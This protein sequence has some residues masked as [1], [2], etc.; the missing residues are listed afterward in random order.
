[1][2]DYRKPNAVFTWLSLKIL[3]VI[4]QH[5]STFTEN[6]E[7]LKD[8][9]PPYLVLGNHVNNWDPFIVNLFL[10]EPMAFVVGERLYQSKGPIG[11]FLKYIGAIPII[12]SEPDMTAV[13]KLIKAKQASRILCL[14][15]EGNRAWDGI[16]RHPEASTAKLIRLLKIPVVT[17]NI[18]GAM[19]SQPRWS[20]SYRK[21]PIELT[22]KLL[23]TKDEVSSVSESVIFN[24]MNEALSHD[25]YEWAAQ[26][27]YHYSGKNLAEGMEAFLYYCK[28]CSSEGTLQT[29]GD[30]IHCTHCQTTYR[31]HPT[32][33]LI[34]DNLVISPKDWNEWQRHLL[35]QRL[36]AHQSLSGKAIVRYATYHR[37]LIESIES[38]TSLSSD[39]IQIGEQFYSFEAISGVNVQRGDQFEFRY[40]DVI[41]SIQFIHYAD[42]VYKWYEAY[43]LLKGA[44]DAR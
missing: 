14:F 6:S 17:V 1:M 11:W 43:L 4:L 15:P 10:K 28:E 31:Y 41:I 23:F 39:G 42:S 2:E 29:K 7:I 5:K 22:Y 27:A 37:Q 13:R 25:E 33:F 3:R 32:G 19:L 20:K 9:S 21:G 38:D 8:L 18:K 34:K 24:R 26:K 36:I 12:K 16:Y 44:Y 35:K 30:E 40:D